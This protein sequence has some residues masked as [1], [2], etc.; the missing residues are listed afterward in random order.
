MDLTFKQQHAER[1]QD[2]KAQVQAAMA[3]AQVERG[4]V[5]L[6]TGHGKGKTTSAFGML[7]RALGHGLR[8]GVVQFITGTHASGEVTFLQQQG[9][10]GQGA[11]AQVDYHAMAT[12]CSW[13]RM[14][15]DPS[16]RLVVLDELTFM[17]QY[18][19][20][21][22]SELLQA[23]ERRPAGQ[24]VVITGRSAP[25]PLLALAD[26]VSEIADTR[27]AFQ[28]GVKAQAGVDF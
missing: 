24:S 26:T 2:K 16:L 6:L 23:L 20:L 19:Y 4:I 7:Y 3:R 25:A 17:L 1:M 5:V 8:V 27:H 18:G 9:L 11:R 13:Q 12:G 22:L 28:A 21:A 10:L 14:L 15:A